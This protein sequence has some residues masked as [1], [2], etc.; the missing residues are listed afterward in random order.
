MKNVLFILL[1]LLFSFSLC[2]AKDLEKVRLQLKWKHQFQFAGYYVAK[3]LGFYEDAGLDVEILEAK[4]GISPA[5]IVENRLADFGVGTTELIVNR[6]K[7]RPF[8]IIAPIFQHSPLALMVKDNS[9]INTVQDLGNKKIMIEPMSAELFAML[10]WEGI[11]KKDITVAEHTFDVE[12]LIKENIDSISVYS[13]DEP[14]ILEK[15]GVGFKLFDPRSRGIDFYGDNIFT[16]SAYLKN[17]RKTVDS[18]LKASTKGWKYALDNKIKTIN[19]I[20]E[21]YGSTKTAEHLLYEAKRTEL[22][23]LP[24]IVEIGYNNLSRW[25]YIKDTYKSLGLL[26]KDFPLESFIYTRNTDNSKYLKV[27]IM[28][29]AFT[30][31]SFLILLR[32]YSLNRKLKEQVNISEKYSEKLEDSE[33]KYKTLTDAA[34]EGIVITSE[35]QIIEINQAALN[36]SGYSKK[37]VIGKKVT[38]FIF[39][40]DKEKVEES[41][42]TG[43]EKPYIVRGVTKSGKISSAEVISRNAVIDGQDVR[44]TSFRDITENNLLSL[45][46][47]ELENRQ[48]KFFSNMKDIVWSVNSELT[49]NY[50]SDSDRKLRGFDNDEVIGTSIISHVY[51]MDQNTVSDYFKELSMFENNAKTIYGNVRLVTKSGDIVHVEIVASVE[52]DDSGVLKGF[53]GWFRDIS[54]LWKK[55]N[56][57]AEYEELL[58]DFS[59]NITQAVIFVD[60][61]GKVKAVSRSFAELFEID[62]SS[63]SVGTDYSSMLIRHFIE[64]STTEDYAKISQ[65]NGHSKII[66][67]FRFKSKNKEMWIRQH[68]IDIPEKGFIKCFDDITDL[69]HAREKINDLVHYDSLTGLPGRTILYEKMGHILEEAKI[70][71]NNIAIFFIDLKGF[72]NINVQHGYDS[73]DKIMKEVSAAIVGELRHNDFASRYGSDDF[74]VVQTSINRTAEASGLAEKIINAVSGEYKIQQ[75]KINLSLNIGISMFPDNENNVD[76]LLNMAK[77]AMKRAEKE[78]S[79]R[80]YSE[81]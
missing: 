20:K 9:G 47:K 26:K 29:A 32:M 64:H 6:S 63:L 15:Q 3:E 45:R 33:R 31:L 52:R 5:D 58:E 34:F 78:N 19:L 18:F 46:L 54:R 21:K 42:R 24:E 10:K 57:A 81:T 56:R 71:N 36:I 16:T 75:N 66:N 50:I 73:G 69:K 41:I 1:I 77:D 28:L 59:S 68:H 22:L 70:Y 43:D 39:N 30:A 27:I 49:I 51:G 48:N 11:N 60:T 61:N 62:Q 79:Y 65:T 37:E 44:I 55:G 40:V 38:D 7:G 4:P 17:N 80:F 25:R 2:D 12:D 8:V 53:Y 23:I 74:V 13:T 14:F 72:K 67:E 76:A 35:G